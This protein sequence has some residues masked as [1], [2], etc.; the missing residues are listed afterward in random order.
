MQAKRKTIHNIN[1]H[2]HTRIH[3][4]WNWIK[5]HRKNEI[6]ARNLT[7]ENDICNANDIVI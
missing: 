1:E 3:M 6:D 5:S 4:N 7:V 2:T